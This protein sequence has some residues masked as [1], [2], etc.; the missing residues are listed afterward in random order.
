MEPGCPAPGEPA[1][2]THPPICVLIA[3]DHVLVRDGIKLLVSGLLGPVQFLE[4]GDGRSLLDVARLHP[5]LKLAL[6]DLNMPGM[7]KGFR[8]TELA[9][10]HPSLAVVVVS[11]LTSPDVVRRAMDVPTVYAFVPKS[12]P[13][14][15]MRSAIEAALIGTRLPYQPVADAGRVLDLA[16]TP[17]LEE[18]RALLRQGMSNKLIASTLGISEGTVKN[19]MTDIFRALN[20]SNRTQAAR[21]DP[22][23]L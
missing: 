1:G 17:R 10:E 19:H 2:A 13:S 8:L 12:A 5:E 3:D 11:A 23:T 7:D 15:R 18:V 21:H 4:A 9:R 20:V 22:D 16:L 6:V 14:D